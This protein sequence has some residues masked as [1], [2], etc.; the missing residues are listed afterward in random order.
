MSSSYPVKASYNA[1]SVGSRKDWGKYLLK[2]LGQVTLAPSSLIVIEE[3]VE[4]PMYLGSLD[5]EKRQT[6]FAIEG[7]TP[8]VSS[9][10]AVTG[11]GSSSVQEGTTI[12]PVIWGF[13]PLLLPTPTSGISRLSGSKALEAM[14]PSLVVI[15]PKLFFIVPNLQTQE[16]VIIHMPKP[17]PYG[18]SHCVTWKYNVSLISTWT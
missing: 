1:I 5:L 10:L 16:G 7:F 2:R 13:D 8:L 11:P 12:V 17:F 14:L 18:D 4:S 3:I 6:P 9:L 15:N